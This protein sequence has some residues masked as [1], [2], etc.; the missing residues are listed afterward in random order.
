MFD[1]LEVQVSTKDDIEKTQNELIKQEGTNRIEINKDGYEKEREE[2][3]DS[4]YDSY[5]ENIKNQYGG[6]DG[7]WN[8]KHQNNK[9]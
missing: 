8:E 3:D 6:P 1:R 7:F 5:L 2:I 4:S 9:K